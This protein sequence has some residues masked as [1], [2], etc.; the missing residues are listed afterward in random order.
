MNTQNG[1]IKGSWNDCF[2][3]D[4]NLKYWASLRIISRDKKY[5][6]SGNVISLEILDDNKIFTEVIGNAPE[7]H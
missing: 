1:L 2:E 7:P 6:Q 3:V 4:N 5:Y